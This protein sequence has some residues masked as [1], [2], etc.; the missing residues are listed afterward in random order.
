MGT[1]STPDHFL[2]LKQSPQLLIIEKKSW[3]LFFWFFSFIHCLFILMEGLIKEQH[4][5]LQAARG[6]WFVFGLFIGDQLGI[7]REIPS[8]L[9]S[10]VCIKALSEKTMVDRRY[11]EEWLHVV[12]DVV[13]RTTSPDCERVW[14]SPK[15]H[16]VLTQEGGKHHMIELAA[17]FVRAVRMEKILSKL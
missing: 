6:A 1:P 4:L 3:Q 2:E 5:F 10:A 17:V 13:H 11:L 16:Q 14:M 7:L 9:P 15:W 12:E 8:D